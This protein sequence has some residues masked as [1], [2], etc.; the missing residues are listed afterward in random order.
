MVF[1]TLAPGQELA[2]LN[3]LVGVHE[4]ATRAAY[5]VVENLIALPELP[6]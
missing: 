4:Y 5:T 3:L 1:P 2:T 6:L